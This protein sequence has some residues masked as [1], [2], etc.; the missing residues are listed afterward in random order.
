MLKTTLSAVALAALLAACGTVPVPPTGD[1]DR[2]VLP[3]TFAQARGLDTTTAGPI[4]AAPAGAGWAVFADPALD[5]LLARGRAANLDLQQAAERVQRSRALAAG[6]GAERRPAVG[7]GAGTRAQQSAESELPGATREQRRSDRADAGLA[8]SWELDLFGRLHHAAAAADRRA[9][10]V[11]ADAE[12]MQIAVAAEIAQAWFTL[13]GTR[14]QL[15]IAAQV[16]ANR[17]ATVDLVQR[18]VGAGYGAPLDDARARADLAAAEAELPALQAALT[19]AGHR[20]A[21]LLGESPSSFEPPPSPSGPAGGA[22][23]ATAAVGPRPLALRLPAPQAWATA[24]PDLRAAEARLR[25]QALDVEA[26]RAEFLP[27]LSISGALG[28]VAGSFSGL[29]AAGSA[30]WFVAPSVSVPLFDGGR[31]EARLQAA[32]AGQREALLAYR[33]RVLLATEEVE[34]A[35]VQ[36]RQGQQR[37]VALQQRAHH[38]V[39]AEGLARKRFEA[40]ST[41]LLELLDAQRT[42]QQ[43]E[44]GLVAAV[45]AQRQQLVALQRALGA[46]FEA[47]GPH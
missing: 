42:S 47:A 14:E 5:T 13:Q 39:H 20:L 41:D 29:G 46:G 7:L 25:A 1:L 45:T 19:V 38:A 44:L 15:A 18:R 10:A 17:R 37:L 27:R 34:S 33:Q 35:L 22:S 11:L 21:V 23:A 31:I 16:V 4:D 8:L 36:V 9:D 40:G 43:A 24:R 3:A 30:A 32:R 28:I 12:A 2:P 6:A 26:V